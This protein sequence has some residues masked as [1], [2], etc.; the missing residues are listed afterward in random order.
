[1]AKRCHRVQ[2]ANENIEYNRK[3]LRYSEFKRI[4]PQSLYS[5]MVQGCKNG[6]NLRGGRERGKCGEELN[7]K[8]HGR[9]TS[10]QIESS[11][12]HIVIRIIMTTQLSYVL[13]TAMDNVRNLGRK[14]L[15]IFYDTRRCCS[16]ISESKERN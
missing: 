3:R 15:S 2:K 4:A 13:K 10:V 1:M 6:R 11:Q 12:Q 8:G 9:W 14:R 5:S 7:G 16:R